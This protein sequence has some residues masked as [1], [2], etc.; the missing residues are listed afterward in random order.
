MLILV[1]NTSGWSDPELHSDSPQAVQQKAFLYP[2]QEMRLKEQAFLW[3]TILVFIVA[4]WEMF[5]VV[6]FQAP[7]TL[8]RLALR[9]LAH[10][11]LA[12]ETS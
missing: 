10:S 2:L 8:R 6:E 12:C 1:S 4:L 7:T 5:N 11:H 3:V 9:R